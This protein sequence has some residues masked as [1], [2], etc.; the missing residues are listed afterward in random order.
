[1]KTV[2]SREL[3]N[4]LGKYLAMARKGESLAITDRGK[5]VAKLVPA[6]EQPSSSEVQ[7]LL[8]ALEATGKVR[9]A[10]GRL[11]RLRP[12]RAKGTPASQLIIEDR[13]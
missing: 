13:R 5:T 1:M 12:V 2:G 6:D 3:K 11:A 9:L 7:E 4:R 10:S 8:K